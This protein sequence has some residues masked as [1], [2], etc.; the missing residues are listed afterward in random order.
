MTGW[1]WEICA[2]LVAGSGGCAEVP[3]S[4]VA[5]ILRMK[6]GEMLSRMINRHSKL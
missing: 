5:K 6:K 2:G 4:C 1:G 3:C